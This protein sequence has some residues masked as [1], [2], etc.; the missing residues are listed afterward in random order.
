[1]SSSMAPIKA[2]YLVAGERLSRD[3]DA[4]TAD[5]AAEASDGDRRGRK[6]GQNKDR[7]PQSWW[8]SSVALCEYVIRGDA[9]PYGEAC[10][11]SHDVGSYVGSK[12]ADIS[13]RCPNWEAT[14]AC[15][16]GA[17]CRFASGHG[18]GG[19]LTPASQRPAEPNA[20]P[21]ELRNALRARR[22][23]YPAADS[24]VE[25]WKEE[26]RRRQAEREAAAGGGKAP[27]A[28][29]AAAPPEPAPSA[30]ESDAESE[31]AASESP[32]V[33]VEGRGGPAAGAAPREFVRIDG[34]DFN[35]TY[36]DL[37]EE[38]RERARR[39]Q[40]RGGKLYLAPLTTVGNLPFRR[41][42]K[43]LGADIT[44]GEMAFA[45]ALLQGKAAE[46]ALLRRHESEDHF[47]VQICGRDPDMMAQ[48]AE[49]LEHAA[50]EI[51]FV[52]VNMGCPLDAVAKRGAGSALLDNPRRVEG[53]VRGMSQIL[54]VPLTVKMRVG[55]KEAS[56]VAHKL[57]PAIA[58]YGAAA[59]ALHGRS[60]L[61]RYSR[62]ADWG[63]IHQCAATVPD[64]PVFGNG[65]I[66]SQ[67]E[68]AGHLEG[69]DLA[70]LMVGRGAL[71]K[72]WL[73][74]EIKERR[75]WDIS[76][77]ERLEL[78]RRFCD[79]GLTHWGSDD[80]GVETTRRYLL[81][82]LSFA[83]RYIPAG[84]L[85]VLPQRINQRAPAYRGRD[86]METLL[87]GETAADWVKISEMFLGRVP[88]GFVFIPKHKSSG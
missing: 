48:A 71:V 4:L 70:G 40:W 44:C 11:K 83:H 24:F 3:D 14:G 80:R 25:Q 16:F 18:A 79:Y 76:A 88:E 54:S 56:P 38:R 30:P 35:F 33:H 28:E 65:D 9:C 36:S 49:L 86:E 59:I 37:R 51:D 69:G 17:T 50:P 78:V 12:P 34:G 77:G 42:C 26:L 6:R 27:E 81:E 29:A 1:M 45:S 32:R 53:I 60:R 5:D 15:P 47:G 87:A 64:T 13:T 46:W 22:V 85:E 10:K 57:I 66:L 61:Q 58:A 68:A 73:F 19:V 84:L 43:D 62:A 2:E 82:W 72:P 52:D 20:L 41:L 55:C 75:T 67:E 7:G 21:G 31:S 8:R 74:R 23:L 39:L 63:Y